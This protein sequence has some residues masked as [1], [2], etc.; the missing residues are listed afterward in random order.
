MTPLAATRLLSR[1]PVFI[2]FL[3][4]I[5]PNPAEA[6]PVFARK[7]NMS[8]IACHSAFP[9]LNAFGEHFRDNNMKL[10]NWR[11]GTVKTGDDRL[12]LPSSAPFA[13]RAQAYTQA[14]RGKSIDPVS[15][16]TEQ[17]S[18]D[19]QSPYLIKLLSSAPL[20]EHLTYYFYGIFAEKGGNGETIIED[21]WFRHDDLFNTGVGMMLGQFQVSDLMFAR[22]TRLSFQDFMVYRMA[23]ITYDRGVLFDRSV[24]DFDIGLGI[25]NG[26]GIE[27]N[28]N[29][30]SPGYRRPDKMFDNN[31]DKSVFARIGTDIGPASVG[32]FGLSGE[33]ANA[34]GPAGLNDGTRDSNK[35]VIGVDLSGDIASKSYW[36]AQF[37]W[38]R[39][40]GFLDRNKDYDWWGGFIGV[41]HIMNDDWTFSALYNFADAND[42]SNTDT[43]YEGIDINS[44]SLTASYYFMRNVKGVA[45][46]NIDFLG[47]DSQK[48]SYYTGHL[49]RE[50]YIL[51]GFDA[52]F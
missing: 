16:D 38:N 48:G 50:D 21:A 13:I 40:E 39:W 45:E 43:V 22:E 23:G 25:V 31:S 51:F 44:L 9:R 30:N 27:E 49:T 41:D 4:V 28:F 32:L 29:I 8:C 2:L 33:Q 52:A 26:N 47:E 7:Y 24:G 36:F 1:I 11:E 6:I 15:G 20:S 18:S 46:V 17:A 35:R 10:P 3:Q 5:L 19:F 12:A 34:T 42:L 14:R 37:L